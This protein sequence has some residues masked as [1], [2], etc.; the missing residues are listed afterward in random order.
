MKLLTWLTTQLN[1]LRRIAPERY[2]LALLVVL[3]AGIWGAV[4]QWWPR[5]LEVTAFAVGDGDAYLIRTPG[6]KA[7]MIDGGSRSVPEIGARVLVPNLLLLGV[8]RLDAMIITH[9]DSDHVNGL[10]DVLEALPTARLLD[11]ELPCDTS[12]YQQVVE[13]ARTRGVPCFPLRAGMRLNLDRRTRLTILAPADPLLVGTRSDSNNNCV[14]CLLE[15]GRTRMLF[16][17]DLEEEGER[18][19]LERYP[20]LSA[21]VT[22]VAHHGSRFGTGDE[23]LDAV[24]PYLAVIS[25]RGDAGGEHPHAS[26][27][28]RLR[29]HGVRILRTDVH[30]QLRLTS[31]GRQWRVSTYRK[32]AQ[33]Q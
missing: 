22:T 19:L 7:V 3:A 15:Y 28:N 16:T 5:P 26:I 21:D 25:S 10:P 6:G 9:P 30:G 1:K 20:S 27:L 29:N 4:W 18:A 31:D 33:V 8:R 17:G 24:H 11:P 14:V 12:A 13:T 23:F 32:A 2:A